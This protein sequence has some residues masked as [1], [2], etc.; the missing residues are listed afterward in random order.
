MIDGDFTKS[1]A[2]INDIYRELRL[3]N[4][5]AEA[6]SRWVDESLAREFKSKSPEDKT[7]RR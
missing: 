1:I 2:A 3:L 6:E 5:K 7:D 4:D